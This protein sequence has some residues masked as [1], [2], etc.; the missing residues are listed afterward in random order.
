MNHK[1]T[2]MIF[3]VLIAIQ[4]LDEQVGLFKLKN[5][6]LHN[7]E[8]NDTSYLLCREEL[9]AELDMFISSY[10]F[11]AQEA[12]FQQYFHNEYLRIEEA[13]EEL[14]SIIG[15]EALCSDEIQPLLHLVVTC[16]LSSCVK[17][18]MNQA[19]MLQVVNAARSY[20]LEENGCTFEYQFCG[21]SIPRN[22]ARSPGLTFLKSLVQTMGSITSK[23]VSFEEV[24]GL[25]YFLHCFACIALLF[26]TT[27]CFY[28]VVRQRQRTKKYI[29]FPDRNLIEVL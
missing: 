27:G 23:Y 1:L 2:T 7:C 21:E 26:C 19:E 13:A 11:E 28:I 25:N 20:L 16:F 8:I 18:N 15:K 10:P 22:R 3:V 6:G 17:C 29:I 5:F 24:D 9:D 4:R 12:V 14:N